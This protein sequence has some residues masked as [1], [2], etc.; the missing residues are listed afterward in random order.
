MRTDHA[1]HCCKP[2]KWGDDY[3]HG[4]W[5]D[6]LV[7]PVVI[8]QDTAMQADAGSE[9]VFEDATDAVSTAEVA[10]Q[11]NGGTVSEA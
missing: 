10:Q 11:R 8:E 3:G 6:G 4:C 1:T 7:N 2:C 9:V 5:C